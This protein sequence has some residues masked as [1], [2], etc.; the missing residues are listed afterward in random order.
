LIDII[1]ADHQEL[2][3]V[4]MAEIVADADD[5]CL[6]AQ[7]RTAEQLLTVPE[8]LIPHVLSCQR[9]FCRRFLSLNVRKRLGAQ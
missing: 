2:F 8:T 4:G 1:F 5:I 7:P 3:H 6:M 9:I